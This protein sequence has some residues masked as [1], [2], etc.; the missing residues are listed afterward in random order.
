[1]RKKYQ[2]LWNFLRVCWECEKFNHSVIQPSNAIYREKKRNQKPLLKTHFSDS[3]FFSPAENA[4]YVP[5]I[6][7]LT[8][9][10]SSW[11]EILCCFRLLCGAVS[12]EARMLIFS[13]FDLYLFKISK[14]LDAE[15]SNLKKWT[16]KK[17]TSAPIGAWKNNY[18]KIMTDSTGFRIRS[19]IDRIRIW[20]QPLRTNRIRIRIQPLRTN[21]IRI[22]PLRTNRIRIRIQ[23]PLS[24][25]FSIYYGP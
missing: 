5:K 10:L 25:K 3:V 12:W 1:M 14:N 16:Q 7:D 17:E 15:I 4:L 11:S 6:W 22:Q 18:K 8:C 24:W 9:G 13:S 23:T 2:P 21:R 19:D 20:I